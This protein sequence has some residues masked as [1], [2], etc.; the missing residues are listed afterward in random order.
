MAEYIDREKLLQDISETV[1]FTV[2]GGVNLPNLEMRGA[3]KVIDQI[4]SSPTVDVA[5]MYDVIKAEAF[6]EFA[7]CVKD[8]IREKVINVA[9]AT[10]DG[11]EDTYWGLLTT[12]DINNLLKEK[13]GEEW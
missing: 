7:E 3:N 5:K 2:R 12:L 8:K 4:K 13:V 9:V 1:V 10:E 6:K 11:K